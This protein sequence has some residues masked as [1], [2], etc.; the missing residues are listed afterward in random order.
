[1]LR[2][3]GDY[4]NAVNWLQDFAANG[5][6]CLDRIRHSQ[7]VDYWKRLVRMDLLECVPSDKGPRFDVY[8]IT[9]KGRS[10]LDASKR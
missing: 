1:M 10:F 8:R 5:E 3:I 6:N 9:D 7:S 4:N 2:D